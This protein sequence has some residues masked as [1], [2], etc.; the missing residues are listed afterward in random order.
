MAAATTRGLGAA[1]GADDRRHGR[2]VQG[3]VHE[4]EMCG[5]GDGE[6]VARRGAGREC[7][8]EAGQVARVGS[9][10]DG[11]GERERRPVEGGCGGS[12]G[13]AVQIDDGV[14]PAILP[15][16]L[17]G[18]R[19]THG[20]A[21]H[22]DPAGVQ[23]SAQRVGAPTPVQTVQLGEDE[24]EVGGSNRR[25]A[26]RQLVVLVRVTGGGGLG[27]D[28]SAVGEDDG[29][30]VVRVV[31][32]GDHVAVAGQFLRPGGVLGAHSARPGRE[33]HDGEPP[34][35]A[36]HRGVEDRTAAGPRNTVDQ[37][38]RQADFAGEGLGDGARLVLR[39][40]EVLGPL[41]ARGLFC[42]G[43][44]SWTTTV[45]RSSGSAVKV[46]GR[47]GSV[48]CTTRVPTANSPVGSGNTG[49]GK[50]QAATG[51]VAIRPTQATEPGN[52]SHQR[53]RHAGRPVRR[54]SRGEKANGNAK[55]APARTGSS[56]QRSPAALSAIVD[57][58]RTAPAAIVTR[59]RA[60]GEANAPPPGRRQPTGRGF[61]GG[62][63]AVP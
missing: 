13:V 2:Q 5:A 30:G 55:A 39:A 61:P 25:P 36:A 9:R 3:A 46:S 38:T 56:C 48:H 49:T 20:V 6:P 37:E 7:L 60:A 31:E 35:S 19:T 50:A 21:G 62:T 22:R 18:G 32:G 57:S 41:R 63:C 26:G 28:R 1:Q 40:S 43:Y 17:Q 54:R 51:P 8:G 58:R 4:R 52:A 42:A 45:R 15:G 34:S 59:G 10:G 27:G 29:G 14:E 23:A 11:L 53:A 33:Q 47:R 12:V 24:A 44:Q 16:R